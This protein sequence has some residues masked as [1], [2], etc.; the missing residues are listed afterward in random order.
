M[1]DFEIRLLLDRTQARRAAEQQAG[2]LKQVEA[3]AARAGKAAGQAGRQHAEG[4]D[5]AKRSTSALSGTLVGLASNLTSLAGPAAIAQTIAEGF[6][7]AARSA[8]DAAKF[9]NEY[10]EALLQFAALRG[11]LGSTGPELR[12]QLKYRAQTLQDSQS[13]I[14]F[15]EA[16]MNIGQASVDT[17][18]RKGLISEEE[19]R[20]AILMGGQFQAA[21]GGEAQTHGQLVGQIPMLL[22]RRTTGEEVFQT[23]RQLFDIFQLGGGSF[24]QMVGQYLGNASLV[25]NKVYDAPQL[26]ALQSAFSLSSPGSAGV[27]VERFTR[28]TLGGLGSTSVPQIE[29]DTEKLGE[30]LKRVGATDQMD[31]V[32]IGRKIVADLEAQEKVAQA[33]G[34]VFNSYNYLR[35]HGYGAMEDIQALMT[36]RGL[37]T[38]GQLKAIE[39]RIGK[40]P[41]IEEAVKPIREF[42]AVEPVAQARRAQIGEEMAQTAVGVG[43]RGFFEN[44]MQTTFNQLKAEGKVT[45][46]YREMMDASV[47][48]FG[49]TAQYQEVLTQAQRAMMTEAERVGLPDVAERLSWGS[50]T[51][52]GYAEL[53]Q[54]AGQEIQQAG[55][56]GMPGFD[57][58]VRKT[59]EV[60]SAV[61][62]QTE[63]LTRAV[64]QGAQPARGV[65]PPALPRAPRPAQRDTR[66]GR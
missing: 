58:L 32:A 53:F 47:F 5:A 65:A 50:F 54:G 11:H 57:E 23:E 2:E 49:Q 14:K 29:G 62:R 41:T 7:R 56:R 40:V 31:P 30:F 36:F 45:G 18:T 9:T 10:R 26:A 33:Q 13:A 52:Q 35:Q 15:Q 39:D 34:R 42:Q 20:K 28:A 12:E 43:P 25:T 6:D 61:N 44:Y 51:Q 38:G 21:E 64:G 66:P 48:N 24:S 55:G 19:F 3:A 22:G 1:P 63:V 4:F 46:G 60:V 17:A 37:E 27:N 8:V 59:D 16:A